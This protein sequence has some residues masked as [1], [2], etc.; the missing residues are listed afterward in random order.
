MRNA[1][2]TRYKMIVVALVLLNIAT[3]ATLWLRPMGPPR[4]GQERIEGFLA[5]ELQLT[6]NQSEAFKKLRN[7]YR[8]Q[9]R[10]IDRDLHDN[11]RKMIELLAQ[12]PPDTAA[13]QALAHRMGDQSAVLDSTLI[14]H[15]MQPR[16][17]CSVEQQS[18]LGRIFLEA[19]R[20]PGPPP[21]KK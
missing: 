13:A 14:A 5:H 6:E 9:M 20:P 8:Q 10:T 21:P 1:T 12:N 3:L 17:I 4:P 18:R 16:A 11:K 7:E 15:F 2:N 19:M